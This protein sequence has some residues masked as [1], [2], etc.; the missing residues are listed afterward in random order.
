MKPAPVKKEE[1]DQQLLGL[2]VIDDVLGR[3]RPAVLL[4]EALM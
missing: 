2:V 3:E 4:K 1:K